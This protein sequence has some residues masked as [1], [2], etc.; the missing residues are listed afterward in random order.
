MYRRS[1][2]KQLKKEG[3]AY[4]CHTYYQVYVSILKELNLPPEQRGKAT[5]LLSTMST[6]FVEFKSR[7]ESTHIFKEV[8]LYHESREFPELEKY[9]KDKGN[10]LFNLFSRIRYTKAL[11]KKNEPL[12]PVDMT[13]FRDIWVFCD[14]DPI[15]YYLNWKKIP[16]HAAEDATNTIYYFDEAWSFN[17]GCFKLKAF[18]SSK[19]N[20]ILVHNGYAKYCIDMEVNDISILER[21]CPKYVEVR[22]RDLEDGVK[23]EDKDSIIQAFVRNREGLYQQIAKMDQ[24]KDKILVLTEP[25]CSME[26]REKLFRDLFQI[27]EKEG[28]VFI[29]PHPRDLLDYPKV[30]PEYPQFDAT[31][32]MEVLNYF[33]NL[34]FRKVVGIWTEMKE[35]RFAD[36]IV[37]LGAEFMDKYEDPEIHGD[38]R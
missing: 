16:Y 11:A 27:Y 20:L 34:R 35:L 31:I 22:L 26:V 29:K 19:L 21:K 30:F 8:V 17:K 24:A 36:E 1:R 32:P 3:R 25:L 18:M 5:L 33:P 14:I 4:V 38:V 12:M 28:E 9:Q 7:V 13:Q 15:G 6:D 2:K 10:I 23:E 37:R